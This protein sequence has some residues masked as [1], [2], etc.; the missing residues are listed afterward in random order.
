[1]S[2]Y[3]INNKLSLRCRPDK[4]KKKR[5]LIE[6]EVEHLFFCIPVLEVKHTI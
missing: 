3:K 4:E 5:S 1:M 6:F 2:Y